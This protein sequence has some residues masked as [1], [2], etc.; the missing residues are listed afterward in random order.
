MNNIFL[1][2]LK[3]KVEEKKAEGE[4]EKESEEDKGKIKPNIGNGADL[5]NY[6][7]VQT[8][9]EIDVTFYYFS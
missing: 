4:D 6:K 2:F 8:L 5:P 7:W 3:K 9:Q 1:C